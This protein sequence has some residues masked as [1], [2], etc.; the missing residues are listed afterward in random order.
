MQDPVE[1]VIMSAV[2]PVPKIPPGPISSA[3][4]P[5]SKVGGWVPQAT[6]TV[7]EFKW[8][9]SPTIQ[10]AHSIPRKLSTG[11][12]QAKVHP[13]GSGASIR[14]EGWPPAVLTSSAV[15]QTNTALESLTVVD[16]VDPVGC[17]LQSAQDP[18][19]I[20]STRP[21]YS[22]EVDGYRPLSLLERQSSLLNGRK[23]RAPIATHLQ[24]PLL[25]QDVEFSDVIPL[26]KRESDRER[27]SSTDSDELTVHHPLENSLGIS[28]VP[29]TALV[30]AS[31][32]KAP[33][34]PRAATITTRTALVPDFGSATGFGTSEAPAIDYVQP[35]EDS[36]LVAVSPQLTRPPSQPGPKV[37]TPRR[38]P[39]LPSQGS[40]PFKLPN[41]LKPSLQRRARR[42][43]MPLIDDVDAFAFEPTSPGAIGGIDVV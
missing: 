9:V 22:Y 41:T 42:Q 39:T 6:S 35:I 32:L 28:N 1:A 38:L 19:A 23:L 13:S 25:P 16:V 12:Q 40:S 26:P 36:V 43:A 30:V 4:P 33:S 31:D 20:I 15:A 34:H 5:H 3:Q 18:P 11:T 14:A 24:H 7:S 21:A 27:R 2:I 8:P 29:M 37:A 17:V 10:A